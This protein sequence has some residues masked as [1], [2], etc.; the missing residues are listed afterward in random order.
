M[1]DNEL[2]EIRKR[3]EEELRRRILGKKETIIDVNEPDFQEKVIERSKE[4]PVVVDFW[5]PWCQPCLFLSPTL[6]KLAREYDGKFILAKINVDQNRFIAQRYGIM[7]IPSVKMFKKGEIVGEFLG[8]MPEP[9]VRGWLD[10]NL[11][12]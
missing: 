12:N 10:K 6:E 4:T 9:H 1:E 5:A 3:K 2:E 7:S 8:A 11:G